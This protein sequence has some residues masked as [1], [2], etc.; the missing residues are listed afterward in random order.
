MFF[1]LLYF[2]IN[3]FLV[4]KNEDCEG[5]AQAEKALHESHR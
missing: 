3:D 1:L 2:N 5:C 4:F